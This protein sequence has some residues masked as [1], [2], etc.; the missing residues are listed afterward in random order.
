MVTGVIKDVPHAS[1]FH[2]DFLISTRKFGGNIDADW[3]FYNFYT[4]AKLKPNSDITAFTKKYR[5]YIKE[6]LQWC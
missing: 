5:T 1:H 3:G 2:F 6:I 4:Y